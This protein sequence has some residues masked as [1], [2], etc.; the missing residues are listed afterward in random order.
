MPND[1]AKLFGFSPPTSVVSLDSDAGETTGVSIGEI[2]GV[3]LGVIDGVSVGEILGVSVGVP[4]IVGVGV[5]VG[6]MFL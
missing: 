4:E 2:V 6:E 1:G 5:T 3:S